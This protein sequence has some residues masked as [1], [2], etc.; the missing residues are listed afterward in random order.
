[1]AFVRKEKE[2]R[3]VLAI[4][5]DFDKTLSPEEMQAQGYIQSVGYDVAQFWKESNELALANDMDSNLAY[6]LK[7]VKEAEGNLILTRKALAEYGSRVK[8]FPGVEEWFGRIRQYGEEHGVIVEHYII[9]SGLKEMIEGTSIA[10]EFEKVYASSFYYNERGVAR[11]PAQTINFTTK[12]QLLF[13]IEKGV[14]DINDTAVN[15]YFPPDKIRVPFRNMVYLG[16]SETDIPCMKLVNMNGGHSIGVYDPVTED[17]EKVQHMIRENR[18]RYYAPADYTEDSDLDRL[19]K[20][21]IRKTAAYEKLED[22]HN[23]NV[24]EAG[25]QN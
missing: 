1:M 22:W 6:M 17:R 7:M 10:G 4:C 8:L 23:S 24:E 13:R 14:L 21:I 18:I 11:W 19:V 20:M 9:S 5:Y 16:D 15:T 2:D 25:R 12:T 3:P